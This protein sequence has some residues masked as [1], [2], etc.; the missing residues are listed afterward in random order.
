VGDK[1]QGGE[2]KKTLVKNTFGKK[3]NDWCDSRV[4]KKKTES[5]M[6]ISQQSCGKV[7]MA[8]VRR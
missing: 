5:R 7:V 4:K 3:S 2:V 8:R 6:L 1:T